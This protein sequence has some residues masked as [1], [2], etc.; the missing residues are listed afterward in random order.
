MF[1]RMIGKDIVV[2][3]LV[4]ASLAGQAF[5][6]DP[7]LT[8]AQP[9]MHEVVIRKDVTVPMRDGIPL[10]VDLYLPGRDGRPLDGRLPTLLA[11]TPYNKNGMVAEARWFAA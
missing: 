11:R 5:A 6:H 10:A 2:V 8:V 7:S 3:L 9:S 1:R 4:I